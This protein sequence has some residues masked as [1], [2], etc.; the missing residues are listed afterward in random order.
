[1]ISR[2]P[3][4]LGTAS[5]AAISILSIKEVWHYRGTAVSVERHHDRVEMKFEVGDWGPCGIGRMKNGRVKDE[6]LRRACRNTINYQT[7]R[8]P[9][10]WGP[11]LTLI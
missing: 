8:E 2:R 6:M 1:M 10:L 7:G 5:L 3:F 11:S 4:L 9:T